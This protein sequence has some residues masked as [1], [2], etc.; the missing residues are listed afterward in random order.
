MSLAGPDASVLDPPPALAE[1]LD[2]VRRGRQGDRAAL[3][4]LIGR[5]QERVRRIVSI[6]MGGQFQGLLDSLDLTQET[7]MAAL[8]GLSDFEPRGHGSLI[9]WLARIA[10]NQVLDA[11]DRV[12]AAR[13]D[14]RRERPATEA[15]AGSVASGGLGGAGG[16][17]GVGGGAAL[18]PAASGPSPSEVAS[19]RE[20][21]ATYDACVAELDPV[22]RDVILLKDYSLLEWTE[23]C[24]QLGRPNV[25]ATQELYRRAQLKLGERLRQR[26]RA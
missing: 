24:E 2:L 15:P 3:D 22:H 18:L 23:V 10:E 14:R 11:K 7:W 4:A 20:L 21:R 9:R 12:Q 19:Q 16:S 1:S 5:Y 8:A 6:R 17:G 25:H 13:R 26:L